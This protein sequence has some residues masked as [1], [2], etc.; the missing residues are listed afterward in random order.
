[1]KTKA[2]T[3]IELLVVLS[4]IAILAGLAYGII[5]TH[6]KQPALYEAWRVQ[7]PSSELTFEQW[8]LLKDD[9]L[10]PGQGPKPQPPIIIHN[11][12]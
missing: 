11:N 1:M 10:L 2:F 4:I 9:H 6:K 5:G 12:H 3:V 7:N 8:K